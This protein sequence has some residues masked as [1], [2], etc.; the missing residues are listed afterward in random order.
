MQQY[1]TGSQPSGPDR[2]LA[3]VWN[4]VVD[5]FIK[6]SVVLILIFITVH[7][8][9]LTYNWVFPD[10]L[11]YSQQLVNS[12]WQNLTGETNSLNGLNKEVTD[13]E[14]TLAANELKLRQWA[15]VTTSADPYSEAGLAIKSLRALVEEDKAL[16]EAVKGRRHK[17]ADLRIMH[18]RRIKEAE[19]ILIGAR[20]AREWGEAQDK[21]LVERVKLILSEG[22]GAHRP[23]R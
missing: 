10:P 5:L 2:D 1:S 17:L 11:N 21:H 14:A 7:V 8:G 6:I 23:P 18:R 19:I 4:G 9:I 15:A 16:L 13:R 12:E 3:V 22:P 20:S